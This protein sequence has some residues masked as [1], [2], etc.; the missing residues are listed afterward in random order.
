MFNLNVY[1]AFY[2]HVQYLTLYSLNM[3]E[4]VGI[5]GKYLLDF[6]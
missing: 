6:I 4:R 5:P 3:V 1:N 2:V